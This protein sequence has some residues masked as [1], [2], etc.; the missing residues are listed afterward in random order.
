[1]GVFCEEVRVRVRPAWY[2]CSVIVCA[3][4]IASAIV[5]ASAMVIASAIA[6]AR[7]M[8]IASAI[9]S[10]MAI[11]MEIRARVRAAGA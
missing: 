7:A 10:V 3:S 8:V 9:A 1:M 6:S 11:V 5:I 4:A 2:G